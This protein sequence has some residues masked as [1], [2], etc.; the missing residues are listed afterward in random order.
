M[1][2]RPVLSQLHDVDEMMRM[3]VPF[4][5]SPDPTCMPGGCAIVPL[6]VELWACY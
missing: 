2:L 6:S 3:C 1:R 4:K 5:L